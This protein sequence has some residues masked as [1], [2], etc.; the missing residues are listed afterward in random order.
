M[1]TNTEH[2]E[3][4]RE[5]MEGFST[6]MLITHGSG[7]T[8]H[9]RP[10]AIAGVGEHTEIW[11]VSGEDTEKVHEIARDTRANVVCQKDH[12]AYLSLA[13][14]INIVRDR[15]RVNDLWKE[16]FRVW[17]PGGKED[18]NLILLRFQP[19]RAEYWDNTGFNK[20][21]Y[22]WEAAKAYVTGEP[23]KIHQE[24]HGVAEM[25]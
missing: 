14:T 16:A 22:L 15:T 19:L 1:K 6:A 24:A 10:M 11:F 8:I 25:V 4:V 7:D 21:A 17:F 18:P 23:P 20:V 5:L 2:A 9:A 13:G 3:R 12:S